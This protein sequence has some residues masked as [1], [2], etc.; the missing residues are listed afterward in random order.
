MKTLTTA[1]L[2]LLLGVPAAC[3]PED[4][5]TNT[6]PLA[7]YLATQEIGLTGTISLA[8]AYSEDVT[9][10][11]IVCPYA[12]DT[13]IE[14]AL[15][16]KWAGAANL[17]YRMSF[18]DMQAVIGVGDGEVVVSEVMK[19]QPFDLCGDR[20]VQYPFSMDPAAVLGIT[21][22]DWSDNTTGPRADLG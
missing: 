14:E 12:I 22:V 20:D 11:V 15:G 13:Q 1:A 7:T 19:R 2:A 17:D 16:F 21:S 8:D 18:E 4:T 3:Q 6:K 5:P 9:R 10:L